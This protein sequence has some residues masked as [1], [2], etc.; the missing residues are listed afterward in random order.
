[1]VLLGKQLP[2]GCVP[3]CRGHSGASKVSQGA[4]SQLL[5]EPFYMVDSQLMANTSCLLQIQELG[6]SYVV[7]TAPHLIRC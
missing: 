2:F 1:M 3:A 7:V 4:H 5:T 6:K